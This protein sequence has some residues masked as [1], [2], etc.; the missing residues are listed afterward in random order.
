MT[1]GIRG[2]GTVQ[3]GM[4]RRH[5]GSTPSILLAL[6]LGLVGCHQCGHGYGDDVGFDSGLVGGD[7]KKDKDCVDRCLGGKDFPK[8]TCSVACDEDAD[9]PD[10]TRCIEVEGGRCLLSC[11]DSDEC[12]DG[13]GCFDRDRH[14]H[15]GD[16]YVCIHD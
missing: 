7:C 1:A 14:G 3:C 13:Y 4:P 11:E 5:L 15:D 10:F 8:G 16:A 2:T 9:C 6:V 12:R